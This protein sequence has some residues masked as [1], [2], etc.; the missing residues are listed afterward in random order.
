MKKENLGYLQIVFAGI[1]AAF[2]PLLV[3]LGENLGPYNLTF[4]KV[5]IPS[6]ILGGF[7]LFNKKKLVPLKYERGKMLLF[8]AIHGFIYL[9]YFLAIQ[10]L[11]I[12]FAILLVYL[13]PLWIMFFSHFI[14]KEKITKKSI[15]ILLIGLIGM[16]I[17]LSPKDLFVTYNFWAILAGIASGIGAAFIYTI[18]KTFKNYDKVSLTFWQNTIAVPFVFPLLFIDFP[19][20]TVFDSF[21]VLA[22]GLIGVF[23]LILVFKGLHK[24]QAIKG[25]IVMLSEMI[26][27]I[28]LAFIFFKEIPSNITVFGGILILIAAFMATRSNK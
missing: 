24:V 8:G 6:I 17:L 7:F 27:P 2:I 3:R 5:L 1:L 28:I 18:S 16:A 26:F 20:F 13:F 25:G 12:A 22:L 4:F 10:Y 23:A 14:L 21:I 9:G 15:F 19:K 11:T